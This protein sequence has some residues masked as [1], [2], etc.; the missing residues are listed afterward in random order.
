MFIPR[1]GDY[2]SVRKGGQSPDPLDISGTV[3]SLVYTAAA[4]DYELLSV[5]FENSPTPI[6][7]SEAD[8]VQVH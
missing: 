2:I 1:V 7:I 8:E 3:K 6:Y 5:I 4:H